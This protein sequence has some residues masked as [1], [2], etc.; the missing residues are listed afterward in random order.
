MSHPCVP[1]GVVANALRAA[2]E[3]MR[4][5]KSMPMARDRPSTA[6]RRQ[7]AALE[8][9]P[10]LRVRSAGLCDPASL[11][12]GAAIP[13]A[14]AVTT[15]WGELVPMLISYQGVSCR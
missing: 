14:P 12:K 9:R 6:W 7:S 15:A 5:V 11:A 1:S 13:E 2:R 4:D 10:V 3:I 8:C